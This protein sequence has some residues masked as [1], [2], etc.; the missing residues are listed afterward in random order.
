V[1]ICDFLVGIV[2]F[3][4]INA[5]IIP[6]AVSIPNVRGVTSSN[7]KS[8]TEESLYPDKIAA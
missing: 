1:N 6:P 2:A 8:L 3:L 7:S 4:L 5:V